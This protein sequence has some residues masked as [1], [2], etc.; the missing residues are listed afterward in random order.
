MFTW[1]LCLK[2]CVRGDRVS[3]LTFMWIWSALT[4]NFSLSVFK[5][6][7]ALLI[8]SGKLE[9]KSSE[10]SFIL[11]S[12]VL[13]LLKS[14]YWNGLE[15]GTFKGLRI[16]SACGAD[17]GCGNEFFVARPDASLAFFPFHFF[18]SFW[19]GRG[20]F[21]VSSS[22]LTSAESPT[23]SDKSFMLMQAVWKGRDGGDGGRQWQGTAIRPT[24]ILYW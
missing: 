14:E 2:L 24:D 8:L 22:S 20:C 13:D 12:Q 10:S 16:R 11:M 15:L 19:E 17:L 4:G 9:R 3:S 1:I 5:C 21:A 6:C 18:F 23:L 7:L